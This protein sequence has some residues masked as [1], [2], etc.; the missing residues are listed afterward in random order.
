MTKK[1]AAKAETAARMERREVYALVRTFLG[2]DWKARLWM[3]TPNP[4][5]GYIKPADLIRMSPGKLLKIVKQQ[6]AENEQ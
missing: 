2:F 1:K 3:R 6:L 5:L 4:L